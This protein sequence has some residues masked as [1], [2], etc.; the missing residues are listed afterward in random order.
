MLIS[1][2]VSPCF[3]VNICETLKAGKLTKRLPEIKQ[4]TRRQDLVVQVS[5]F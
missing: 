2:F 3:F 1:L 5:V 4:I